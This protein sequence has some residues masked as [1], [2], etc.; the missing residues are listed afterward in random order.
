VSGSNCCDPGKVH[1]FPRKPDGTF[2]ARRD[3]SFEL[4]GHNFLMRGLS[5]PH[6]LDWNRDGHT[7]LVVG[8]P[9]DWTLHV[10]AGP[11]AGKTKV[12]VKPFTLPQVPSGSPVHFGFAD[13]DGD[14]N[15][16]L[17]AG[18]QF[19]SG[20]GKDDPYR[21]GIHWFRNTSGKGEPNFAAASRLLTIPAPWELE[22]FSVV[23][24]DQDGHLDLVVSVTRDWKAPGGS[25][26]QLWLYRRRA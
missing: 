23:D 18:L 24:W 16:D 2:G 17:I 20:K 8:Y 14:G 5:R 4:P 13:W 19:P 26:N 3:I 21:Y 1:L 9:R 25:A 22:A 11:L 15:F 12:A 6:L 7:D 10:S